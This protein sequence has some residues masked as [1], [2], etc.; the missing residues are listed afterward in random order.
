MYVYCA[1]D[2]EQANLQNQSVQN[3]KEFIYPLFEL[4]A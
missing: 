4:T 2:S 3:Q 1:F